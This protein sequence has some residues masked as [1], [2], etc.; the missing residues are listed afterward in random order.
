MT[1]DEWFA[2][3][4]EIREE[5]LQSSGD[6]PRTFYA[7]IEASLAAR[8][9]LANGAILDASGPHPIVV[10][11]TASLVPPSLIAMHFEDEALG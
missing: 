8:M 5:A 1:A 11:T 2:E 9:E 10:I 7:L 3:L 6:A 4:R